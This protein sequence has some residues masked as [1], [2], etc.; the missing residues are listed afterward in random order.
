M[1]R[2]SMFGKVLIMLAIGWFIFG[3]FI[4]PLDLNFVFLSAFVIG[5][6]GTL[7]W[8]SSSVPKLS[9]TALDEIE[10]HRHIA[11]PYFVHDIHNFPPRVSD[12]R[13]A[14]R[15]RKKK[16]KASREIS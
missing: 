3:T 7:V 16:G 9:D 5:I 11:I 4:Y 2:K 14:A 1:A 15:Q 13:E 12:R 6:F 8:A 10:R